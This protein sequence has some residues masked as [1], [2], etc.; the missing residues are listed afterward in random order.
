MDVRATNSIQSLFWPDSQG[1]SSSDVRRSSLSYPQ[2]E[3]QLSGVARMSSED[4]GV[5]EGGT[6]E[7]RAAKLRRIK[8]E[9]E[10]GTYD[11]DEKLEIAL[12]RMMNEL[13]GED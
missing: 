8:A 12:N 7:D 3:L 5:N 13:A 6:S 9:I 2:D 11:T 4:H 10:A 1:R